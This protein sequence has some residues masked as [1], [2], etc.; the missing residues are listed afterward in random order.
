MK[1]WTS[2]VD[3][4]FPVAMKFRE[5]FKT[6]IFPFTTITMI[7]NNNWVYVFFSL[8][9]QPHP[10]RTWF[11]FFDLFILSLYNYYHYYCCFRWMETTNLKG[12]CVFCVFSIFE[13][14]WIHPIHL[15]LKHIEIM[16]LVV[17]GGFFLFPE[18]MTSFN[19]NYIFEAPQG[20]RQ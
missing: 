8:D 13:I 12:W 5:N 7:T 6:S 10:F 19:V 17:F 3:E 18:K 16:N 2:K 11:P 15:Y 9:F 20:S 14:C 4:R 1:G